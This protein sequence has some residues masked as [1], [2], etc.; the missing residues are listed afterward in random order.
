MQLE[1][2]CG[3]H[4]IALPEAGVCKC[5]LRIT[6]NSDNNIVIIIILGYCLFLPVTG[7]NSIQPSCKT[8][9]A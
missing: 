4:R 5:A 9:L 8:S 2:N 3:T 7:Y 1:A 6:C